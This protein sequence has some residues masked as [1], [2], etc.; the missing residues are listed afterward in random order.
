MRR[1]ISSAVLLAVVLCLSAC[2]SRELLSKASFVPDLISPNGD[3]FSDALVTS[4]SPL[5]V[6]N[7]LRKFVS[8]LEALV[9]EVSKRST[10]SEASSQELLSRQAKPNRNMETETGKRGTTI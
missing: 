2:G 9:Q 8:Y 7:H 3:V 1:S 4:S 10:L 5:E 6:R